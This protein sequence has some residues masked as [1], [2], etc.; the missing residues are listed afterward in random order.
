MLPTAIKFAI[1]WLEQHGSSTEYQRR[2]S[3]RQITPV[4]DLFPRGRFVGQ[5]D[6]F[7]SLD[8]TLFYAGCG[9]SWLEII[10]NLPKMVKRFLQRLIAGWVWLFSWAFDGYPAVWISLA[11]LLHPLPLPTQPPQLNLKRKFRPV[12]TPS[13]PHVCKNFFL[14]SDTH[15]ET[16]HTCKIPIY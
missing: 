1:R 2:L 4:K 6:Q 10:R 15:G 16:K 5:V 14:S 8:L 13:H 3:F 7:S 11:E 12:T 9:R